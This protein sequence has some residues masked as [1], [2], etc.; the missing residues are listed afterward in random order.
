VGWG[1]EGKGG[2]EMRGGRVLV[3][4]IVEKFIELD[5]WGGFR[6]FSGWVVLGWV[7]V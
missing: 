5:G 7:G 4:E 1:G 2:G 3:G 6:A